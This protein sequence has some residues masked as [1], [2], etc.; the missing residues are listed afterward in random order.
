MSERKDVTIVTLSE[1]IED[2]RDW[3]DGAKE[4]YSDAKGMWPIWLI[5]KFPLALPTELKGVAV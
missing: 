4:T 5:T 2:C 3:F 1:V